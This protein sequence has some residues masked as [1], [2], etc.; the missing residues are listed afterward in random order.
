[1]QILYFHSQNGDVATLDRNGTAVA[2][3]EAARAEAVLTFADMLRD[4]NQEPLLAGK[5][6]RLWITDKPGDSGKTLFSLC[7]AAADASVSQSMK[8]PAAGSQSN[9]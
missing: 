9:S 1:V 8:F 6:L 7:A 3:L 4:D 2:N 5:P